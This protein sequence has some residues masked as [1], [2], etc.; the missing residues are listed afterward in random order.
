LA[1]EDEEKGGRIIFPRALQR[2]R[3]FREKVELEGKGL[4]VNAE[5]HFPLRRK[6]FLGKRNF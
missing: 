5:Q 4:P 1:R 3:R 6:G 2:A